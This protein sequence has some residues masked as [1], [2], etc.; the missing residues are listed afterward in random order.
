MEFT[1]EKDPATGSI[2][3]SGNISL[4]DFAKINLDN[5]DRMLLQDKQESAADFLLCLEM[6]Y[7]RHSEQQSKKVT[8]DGAGTR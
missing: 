1:I 2:S 7:R 8:K 4:Y 6:L 5:L 3:F